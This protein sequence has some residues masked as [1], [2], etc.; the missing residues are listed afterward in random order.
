VC[1]G[2]CVCMF[3]GMCVCEYVRVCVHAES[4]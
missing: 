4:P 2:V 3:V 1:V